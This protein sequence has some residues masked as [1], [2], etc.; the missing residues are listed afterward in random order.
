MRGVLRL[1]VDTTCCLRPTTKGSASGCDF[2][3]RL[4]VGSLAL[5]PGDSFTIPKMALSIGF[6]R[7]VSSAGA[8]QATRSLT[9]TSVGLTPTEHASLRWTHCGPN[10]RPTPCTSHAP[11]PAVLSARSASK[12]SRTSFGGSK[13]RVRYASTKGSHSLREEATGAAEWLTDPA[14]GQRNGPPEVPHR[15]QDT[16]GSAVVGSSRGLVKRAD[17]RGM[18]EPPFGRTDGDA[19]SN[20]LCSSAVTSNPASCGRFKTGQSRRGDGTKDHVLHLVRF[21]KAA[22]L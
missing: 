22:P 8:I 18:D 6:S 20:S 1:G 21:R 7:F 4:P 5:R 16:V 17:E 14:R 15:A 11:Y 12:V 13:Q 2:L 19:L 3:T 9:L 10:T